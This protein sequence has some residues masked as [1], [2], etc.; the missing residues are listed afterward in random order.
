M[1]RFANLESQGADRNLVRPAS[2]LWILGTFAFSYVVMLATASVDSLWLPDLLVL[3]LIYWSV[4][5]PQS[6]GMTIAFV[7]GIL[8]DV[9]NGSVLGQQAL[10]YVT[11]SYLAFTLHRRLPWFDLIGQA[12]H[13][14]PML[15]LAQ[16][17]VMLVRLWFD[18][19]W[20]GWIWFAQSVTG[21]CLWPIWSMVLSLR[22][23]ESAANI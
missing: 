1:N 15:L 10:A 17:L 14:L 13:V 9:A 22:R 23:R 11:L 4:H 20:P 21:A 12:L 7:C 2:S 8:M 16:I 18:G 6:V 19:L 5:Q 3:T